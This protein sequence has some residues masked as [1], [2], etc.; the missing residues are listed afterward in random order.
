MV[1]NFIAVQF[2]TSRVVRLHPCHSSVANLHA[3]RH[4]KRRTRCCSSKLFEYEEECIAHST[5]VDDFDHSLT[6][7]LRAEFDRRFAD[8][9]KADAQ[10]F[11]WDYWHVPGQYRLLRTPADAFFSPSLYDSLEDALISFGEQRLGCR[12]I[13]PIWLSYYIDGCRQELHTDAPHG[14]WAFVYSL[15]R[16]EERKFDGGETVLLNNSVI[17]DNYW[18]TFDPS[19]GLETPQLTTLIE[20]RFGR[21]SVFDPR[22]PH[23]VRIVEGV[24]DPRQGRIVLHGWFTP[25]TP[26]FQGPLS[27]EKATPVL[28]AALDLIYEELATLPHVVGTVTVRLRVAASGN[29]QQVMILTNTIMPRYHG[30]DIDVV[31]DCIRSKLLSKQFPSHAGDAPTDITLPFVFE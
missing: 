23:G 5:V 19:Q 21:L 17:L 30:D 24:C 3:F 27:H 18:G 31:L 9:L 22:I 1:Q 2:P 20:P 29:V 13:S 25:P 28:N 10:R 7:D 26:F 11:V 16:W 12:G 4:Q 14:P 15:T 6:R 8:P